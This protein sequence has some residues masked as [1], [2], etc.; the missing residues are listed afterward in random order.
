MKSASA[1]ELF[2]YWDRLRGQ[3]TAPDRAQIEPEKISAAL[4]DTF[5]LG[6]D[7]DGATRFRLAGMRLCALVGREVKG[8][9]FAALWTARALPLLQELADSVC[10]DHLALVANA[11]ADNPDGQPVDLEMLLLPLRHGRNDAGRMIGTLAPAAAIPYWLGVKPA[12][13]LALGSFRFIGAGLVAPQ[14]WSLHTPRPDGDGPDSAPA[15]ARRGFRV[16]DGGLGDR[17]G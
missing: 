13:A 8:V 15:R 1:R 12:G 4:G 14:R 10:E 7:G 3:R 11:R 5:I 16:Y 6:V 9:A 2:A 17:S